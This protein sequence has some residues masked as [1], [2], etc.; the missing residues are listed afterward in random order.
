M[1]FK[2]PVLILIIFLLATMAGCSKNPGN[3]LISQ[4]DGLV[5]TVTLD[6]IKPVTMENT[7]ITL[8]LTENNLPIIGADVSLILT[9]PGMNMPDNTNK[10]I[11]NEPGAYS[12]TTLLSMAGNWHIQADV[13]YNA[14]VSSFNFDFHTK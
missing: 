1:N 6:P 13:T 2:F 10:A 7:V 3:D 4:Q 5:A 8:N 11:E 12:T 14:K 9:M